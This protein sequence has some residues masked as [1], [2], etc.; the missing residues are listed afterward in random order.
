MGY[1]ILFVTATPAEAVVISKIKGMVP[2]NGFYTFGDFTVEVLITGV[3]G[4]ST[5]Y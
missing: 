5:A 1:K 2:Q 3:G 4:I